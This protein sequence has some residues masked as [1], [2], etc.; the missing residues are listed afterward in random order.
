MVSKEEIDIYQNGPFRL[1]IDMAGRKMEFVYNNET[2]YVLVPANVYG[3]EP[4]LIQALRETDIVEGI[5]NHEA[6]SEL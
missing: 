6:I 3:S 5:F 2:N 1:K 4:E